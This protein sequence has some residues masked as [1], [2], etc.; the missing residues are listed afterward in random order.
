LVLR[1]LNLSD[2]D[3]LMRLRSDERV[4]KYLGRAACASIDEATVFIKKIHQIITDRA[5]VYW[6]ISLK[7]H[8]Q[9][10]GT[11]CYW[12]LVPKKDMAEIGYEL[13]PAYHGKGLMHEAISKVIDYA[14]TEMEL[15]VITALPSADN[16]PSVKLLKR[17]G[18][19]LDVEH[20]FVSKEEA[21]GQ[22]VY[23]LMKEGF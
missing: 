4:N 8:A 19:I 10:I 11:I 18:F 6:V 15:K 23:M 5:G 3:D 7:E 1:P 12:N 2:R 16:A 13:F 22:E 17:A 21:E 14:F 9:L 20:Q